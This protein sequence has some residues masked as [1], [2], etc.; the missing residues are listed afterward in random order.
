VAVPGRPG[1]PACPALSALAPFVGDV[2]MA[3][4]IVPLLDEATDMTM[5]ATD[6]DL[7]D[8]VPVPSSTAVPLHDAPGA[9]VP[10]NPAV[11]AHVPPRRRRE[12]AQFDSAI[13][14]PG[15]VRMPHPFLPDT[16]R[17]FSVDFS[18]I[19]QIDGL[20]AKCLG[21]LAR[22]ERDALAPSL[23]MSVAHVH[24]CPKWLSSSS[25]CGLFMCD[26]IAIPSVIATV[27]SH[28]GMGIFVVPVTPMTAP[29]FLIN[30]KNPD[31]TG[32]IR[33]FPWYDYL[34]SFS[35]ITF[36]LPSTVFAGLDGKPMRFQPL[37]VEDQ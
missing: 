24:S 35:L 23:D 29:A 31:G 14:C 36:D 28:R 11:Q 18:I 32:N 3:T 33:R 22:I 27:A 25:F 1:E 12:P 16:T 34:M 17:S 6:M 9:A 13:P 7:I 37:G 2:D 30:R 8:D 21:S 19:S 20:S 26:F 10:R 4:P 15:D 5:M